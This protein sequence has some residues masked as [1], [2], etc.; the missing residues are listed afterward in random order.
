METINF[1][2]T[3]NAG[4]KPAKQKPDSNS[5]KRVIDAS[6]KKPLK[7]NAIVIARFSWMQKNKLSYPEQ[8]ELPNL[9]LTFREGK[10]IR[11]FYTNV[12][13]HIIKKQNYHIQI[14][15]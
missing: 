9:C 13:N 6:K 1:L 3:S 14:L 8:M 7:E 4:C 15:N 5:I 2:M 11:A 10:L 12:M